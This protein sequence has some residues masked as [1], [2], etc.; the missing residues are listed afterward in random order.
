MEVVR[1]TLHKDQRSRDAHLL[2][3][4]RITWEKFGFGSD[5]E[6]Y[7]DRGELMA[8]TSRENPSLDRLLAQFAAGE[9]EP[10]DLR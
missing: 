4:Q 3:Q 9:H 10:G 8:I 1:R 2:E 7:D 5:L 6:I